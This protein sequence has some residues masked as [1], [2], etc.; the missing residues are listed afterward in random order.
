MYLLLFPCLLKWFY[1]LCPHKSFQWAGHLWVLDLSFNYKMGGHHIALFT[2]AVYFFW[3]FPRSS[4]LPRCQTFQDPFLPWFINFCLILLFS[5]FFVHSFPF[6][7]QHKTKFQMHCKIRNCT[8][9]GCYLK[10]LKSDEILKEDTF[11]IFKPF[12]LQA[13]NDDTIGS[14][15]TDGYLFQNFLMHMYQNPCLLPTQHRNRISTYFL[16]EANEQ[17][18]PL[19]HLK[20]NI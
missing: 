9:V 4:C 16:L 17:K 11:Y 19:K 7:L 6:L 14:A 10:I 8:Q 2:C 5:P 15:Y 12:T 20:N 18:H 3:R 1:L 13:E